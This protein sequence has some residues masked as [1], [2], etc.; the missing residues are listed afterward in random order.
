M[1]N[2]ILTPPSLEDFTRLLR[3]WRFWVIGALLGGLLGA[4]V[5]YVFPPEYRARATVVMDFNVEKSWP[6]EPDSQR[7][8]YLERE[9]RKLEEVAWADDTLHI[10]AAKLKMHVD[11]L[12]PKL[13][14]SQPQDGGWH[15]Y[16]T[17]PQ[18]DAAAAL[19]SAW[20]A[21]FVT[22]IRR[23]MQAEVALNA[24]REELKAS[25][26]DTTIQDAITELEAKS[27]GITADLQISPA[28]TKDLSTTRKT[29]LGTYVLA[30]AGV[31]LALAV[32][33]VLFKK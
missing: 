10:V 22:Q 1:K 8:Y 18:P 4:A 20:A 27:L 11:A 25:P 33:W 21:A 28:Q 6:D 30:G 24:A 16:A 23:G 15:F 19:A 17:D 3:A 26:N 7:F 14:L 2:W 12:R 29:G 31:L 32:L 9:S 5:Y 13:E